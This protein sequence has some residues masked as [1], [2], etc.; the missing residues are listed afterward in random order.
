MSRGRP[1]TSYSHE[2]EKLFK[3]HYEQMVKDDKVLSP[4]NEIWSVLRGKLSDKCSV[5]KPEKTIY[6]AAL[7]WYQN[8]R[9]AIGTNKKV[10]LFV[11]FV[12]LC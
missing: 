10:E 7:K 3:E 1:K 5:V 11:I 4:K 12:V 2:L 9:K 8:T 6:T